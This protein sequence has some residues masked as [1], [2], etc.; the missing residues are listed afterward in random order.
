MALALRE[1]PAVVLLDIGLPVLDG[2]QVCKA[3]R[4]GGL[5]DALIVAMSGYGRQED[6]RRAHTVGFDAYQVKP[7]DLGELQLLIEK[8][9]KFG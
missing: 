5:G 6:R 2:F 9:A 1:R 4:D 7:V 8:T 3:M